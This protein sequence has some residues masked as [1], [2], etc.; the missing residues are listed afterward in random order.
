MSVKEARL[1]K[2][3]RVRN[4]SINQSTKGKEKKKEFG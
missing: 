2:W 1:G 4:E 3:R